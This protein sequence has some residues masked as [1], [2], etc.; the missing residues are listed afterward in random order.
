VSPAAPLLRSASS[1]P[2]GGTFGR[3]GRLG[4]V[5][6][7][8]GPLAADPMDVLRQ[9][10]P[11]QNGANSDVLQLPLECGVTRRRA[12]ERIATSSAS[13]RQRGMPMSSHSSV[14]ST[15]DMSVA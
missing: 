13:S 12:S 10:A 11:G 2:E 7:Q 3:S 8:P 15:W 6:P 14:A 9:L 4:R 1:D 5:V